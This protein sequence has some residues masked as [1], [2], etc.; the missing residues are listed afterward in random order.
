MATSNVAVTQGSGKFVAT[1]TITEDAVTKD[2]QRIILNNTSGTE[3]G[4]SSNPVRTDPTNA[5]A[6]VLGAGSSIIGKTTTDQTTHGTTDLVAADITKIAGTAIVSGGVAGS[7]SV[8]GPTASGS[9]LAASPVTTGG[10]GKTANPTAITDG[11]VVNSLH[12]KLGKQVVVGSLRDLKSN[13]KTTITS[14]TSETT[15]ITADATNFLDL[16]G[17]IISNTSA[18]ASTVT[19]KDATSGTTRFILIVP[20]GDTRGFMLPEGG[21]HKQAANNN[22]WTATCGTSVAS[23]E[24][25]ALFVKN[26]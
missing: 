20:A 25:T 8:G 5:T 18:T 17:L 12:D 3:I 26:L 24:I 2:I 13:Q 11:Q 22:N 19:I 21:A 23:I 6:T 14:S 9:S 10:L 1:S 4:T 7:Q 15:I 16:Y